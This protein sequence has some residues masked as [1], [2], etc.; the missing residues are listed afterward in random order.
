[1][2][3]LTPI[4][5]FHHFV[6]QSFIWFFSSSYTK[7]LI[8]FLIEK[9]YLHDRSNEFIDKANKFILDFLGHETSILSIFLFSVSVSII[10][11]IN[12]RKIHNSILWL[13]TSLFM[14]CISISL[15]ESIFLRRVCFSII[16][17]PYFYYHFKLLLNELNSVENNL[18]NI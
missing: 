5:F 1:M 18:F 15:V 17:F 13:L 14:F 8:F 3:S 11:E 10:V 4:Y 6:L 16:Y 9:F 2:N 7:T 12:R